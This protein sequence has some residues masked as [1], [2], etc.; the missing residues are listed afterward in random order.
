MVLKNNNLDYFTGDVFDLASVE[1][2]IKGHDAVV[3][4]LGAGNDLKKTTVRTTGTIN[5]IK[6]M[7]KN[8]VKRL[9]VMSAMGVGNSWDSLSLLNK[10][11]FATLL[12][13]SREDHESQETAVIESGL[14][15]TI[16]R[17]SG[18]I[19]TPRTGVY[20]A[21]ENITAVTSKIARADI[22]DLI[23][24]ELKQNVLIGKAV[25]ITN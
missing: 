23:L 17:P 4:A 24:K 16:I 15:W 8:K 2:A 22:A 21:G 13:S 6:S 9:M 10:I 3:C 1:R 18:L 19:D 7:K 11:Y 12:K 20:K 5:I 25:T 14:E